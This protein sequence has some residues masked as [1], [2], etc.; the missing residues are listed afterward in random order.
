MANS[1]FVEYGFS[2]SG[3][4]VTLQ[5]A[6]LAWPLGTT[7]N[8]SALGTLAMISSST[9]NQINIPNGSSLEFGGLDWLSNVF[10]IG[11]VTNGGTARDCRVKTAGN[12]IFGA[13]GA[14][15]WFIDKATGNFF[16]ISDNAL[17]IGATAASRPR[18]IFAGTRVTAPAYTVGASAGASGTGTVL[19]QLTVSNGIVTSITIS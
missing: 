1:V 7:L 6:S 8:E 14:D 5:Q 4:S 12:L 9:T 18:N 3:S 15:K 2:V 19:T 10:E 11:N 16:A 13:N 17:D